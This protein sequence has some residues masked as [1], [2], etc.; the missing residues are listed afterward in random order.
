MKNTIV[1]LV[2][3]WS[4]L[5]EARTI[6][7]GSGIGAFYTP[8]DGTN[9]AIAGTTDGNVWETYW[10]DYYFG[11]TAFL[12][13]HSGLVGV[14]G[15]YTNDDRYRHAISATSDGTIWEC[16]YNPQVGIFESPLYTFT[17][18]FYGHI[19][20]VTGHYNPS[21]HYRYVIVQFDNGNVYEIRY[22]P[23][24]GIQAY[25]L[26]NY[27][28]NGGAFPGLSSYYDAYTGTNRVFV[29]AGGTLIVWTGARTNLTTIPLTVPR[30]LAPETSATAV[31]QGPYTEFYYA[32]TQN[33]SNVILQGPGMNVILS[34]P[35]HLNQMSTF[36]DGAGLGHI[37]LSLDNQGLEDLI[38]D[39]RYGWG[40]DPI[41]GP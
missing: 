33:G 2:I 8:D 25:Y 21:D 41:H 15:F 19:V 22:H 35:E 38:S 28:W 6:L 26:R 3:G 40:L 4:A 14:A 12:T 29:N 10:T 1:A 31:G 27:N 17:P 11:N 16:Y 39:G 34:R 18:A 13:F 23:S 9:H 7:P 32:G 36:I 5:A 24:T 37:I 20:G 30:T